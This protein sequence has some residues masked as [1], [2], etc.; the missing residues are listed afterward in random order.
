MKDTEGF[1]GGERETKGDK[2]NTLGTEIK[3][4]REGLVCRKRIT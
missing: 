3:T 1:G 4:F 2:K